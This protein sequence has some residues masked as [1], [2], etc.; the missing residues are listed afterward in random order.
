MKASDKENIFDF[1]KTVKKKKFWDI[2][3]TY[4]YKAKL[5]NHWHI[6]KYI[7]LYKYFLADRSKINK[8]TVEFV[9]KNFEKFCNSINDINLKKDAEEYFLSN[10]KD[11]NKLIEF[12]KFNDLPEYDDAARKFYMIRLMNIGGSKPPIQTM[13][14]KEIE[15]NKSMSQILKELPNIIKKGNEIQKKR[16]KTVRYENAKPIGIIRD[17]HATIRNDRALFSYWGFMPPEEEGYKL[18]EIANLIFNCDNEILLGAIGDHQKFK[19]RIGNPASDKMELR[20]NDPNNIMQQFKTEED[21][22]DYKVNPAIAIIEI[23]EYLKSFNLEEDYKFIVTRICPFN[24]EKAV[25]LIKEIKSNNDNKNL[26]KIFDFLHEGKKIRDLRKTK[27]GKGEGF[28]KQIQNLIYGVNTKKSENKNAN[29]HSLMEYKKGE[30]SIIKGKEKEFKKYFEKIISIKNFLNNKYKDEYKDFSLEYKIKLINEVKNF[31]SDNDKIKSETKKDYIKKILSI[32]KNIEIS[33]KKEHSPMSF[34]VQNNW[35][36]YISRVDEK[37]LTYCFSLN[38]NLQ[39]IKYNK[40]IN[41]KDFELNKVLKNFIRNEKDLNYLRPVVIEQL[42]KSDRKRNNLE[43]EKAVKL[44]KEKIIQGSKNVKIE[45]TLCDVCQKN[46]YSDVHH[47]IPFKYGGPCH[48]LNYSF[49]CENCHSYFTFK[50]TSPKKTKPAI[51]ELKIKN[52]INIDKLKFLIKENL[53]G[54]SQIDFL[55]FFKY[56]HLGQHVE[57][58]KQFKSKYSSDERILSKLGLKET[59]WSRQQKIIFVYRITHNYFMEKENFDY[60]I[61]LC[62]GGCGTNILENKNECHHIIPKEQKF[63]RHKNK[64]LLGPNSPFNYAFLCENCHGYFTND[65]KEQFKIVDFFKK[66]GLVSKDNIYQ[67]ILNDDL[68]NDQL[69]FLEVDNY[70]SEDDCIWLKK[71]IEL[72]DYYRSN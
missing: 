64:S 4:L 43:R 72:R 7:V 21:F 71:K 63:K 30:I 39:N 17:F 56:I 9:Y 54:K 61:H 16:G 18:N 22:E 11:N 50:T 13:V 38:L 58:I 6:K 28:N 46:K 68:T 51:D 10:L 5:G 14:F 2:K 15:K 49:L 27:L 31:I 59:R 3:D 8:T 65:K 48:I 70:I 32:K 1:L 55:L 36:N 23:L 53:V 33:K 12:N 60:P 42:T 26:K 47:I 29:N 24:V 57:L 62:D 20:K 40:K 34:L 35:Q 25:Q 45:S 19:M 52:L 44:R 67:M 37:L 69:D 66:T 41:S